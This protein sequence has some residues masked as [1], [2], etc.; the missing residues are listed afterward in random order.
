MLPRRVTSCWVQQTNMISRIWR[1]SA[2]N[3]Y[4][5]TS[6]LNRYSRDFKILRWLCLFLRLSISSFCQIYTRQQSWKTLQFSS[7]CVTRRKFLPSLI[8]KPSLKVILTSYLKFLSLQLR[9]E[10][11]HH[12][13]RG[14][15]GSKKLGWFM[16]RK[17]RVSNENFHWL[18]YITPYVILNIPEWHR[19]LLWSLWREI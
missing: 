5:L 12:Q 18:H 15:G 9:Q 7:Y 4:Q 11:A 13:I 14:G 19:T 10:G 3:A 16:C 8:G 1:I 17:I 2:V 6:M